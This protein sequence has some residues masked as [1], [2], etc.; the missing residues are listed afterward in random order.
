MKN[1]LVLFLS[2][3]IFLSFPIGFSGCATRAE[4]H[5][6]TAAGSKYFAIIPEQKNKRETFPVIWVFPGQGMDVKAYAQMWETFS[7]QN[8]AAV[9]VLK[10]ESW[11]PQRNTRSQTFK[12]IAEKLKTDLPLDGDRMYLCGLSS[13]AGLVNS[14]VRNQPGKWKGVVWISFT[15]SDMKGQTGPPEKFPPLLVIHGQKA[16]Q[17]TYTQAVEDIRLL[18]E[19]GMNVEWFEDPDGGHEH[20]PEW[21]SEIFDWI[22]GGKEK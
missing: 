19:A 16:E 18:R 13:G 7:R 15:T 9:I 17:F 3:V 5:E 10:W 20:R 22:S 2:A 1:P 12:S 21:T 8:R 11:D 6:E 4:L 14:V